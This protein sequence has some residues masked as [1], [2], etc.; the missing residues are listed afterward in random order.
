[1]VLDAS[2]FPIVSM[3]YDD[4]ANERSPLEVLGDLARVLDR[5]EPFVMFGFGFDS[6]P[7]KR[8]KAIAKQ[9]NDWRKENRERLASLCRGMVVVEP[10]AA[11]RLALNAFRPVFA[12]YWGYG[13]HL[14][15]TMD[16]ANETANRLLRAHEEAH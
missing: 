15:A 5:R 12:N 2:Q 3:H 10:S 4:H 16:E 1:M 6:S 7:P 13:V 8:D 14:V 9:M 11:K